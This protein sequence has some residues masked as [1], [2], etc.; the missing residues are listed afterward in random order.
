MTH[1]AASAPDPATF[2]RSRRSRLIDRLAEARLDAAVLTD[3]REIAYFT[4][5]TLRSP[6]PACLLIRRTGETLLVCGESEHEHNADEIVQYGWHDGGT[7][8]TD[9]TP[10][11]L[12]EAATR[13][14]L[15]TGRIGVQFESIS[16]QVC[17]GLGL[18]TFQPIDAVL[19]DLERTKDALDLLR[20]NDAIQANLAALAAAERAIV[21]GATELEVFAAACR[22]AMLRAGKKVVHDG[23][24]RCGAPGGSCRNR[25]IASGEIYTIDAWTQHNGYWSDL[26]R[27]FAVGSASN[28]QRELVEHVRGAHERVLPLLKPGATG[29]ELWQALDGALREHASVAATGLVHH[30]GHGVGLRLHEA[31]DINPKVNVPLRAGDVICIEPGAYTPFANIRIEET[32]L[33]TANGARCLSKP[34]A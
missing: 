11:M 14:R 12:A 18:S 2:A 19:F 3:P 5:S 28:E 4:A 1:P 8:P 13:F 15:D 23:D 16:A 30:G 27:A 20:I 9:L 33:I 32:Y 7:I 31:P 21:P 6:A 24:Y 22:G 34:H 10:R 17:R 26:A 25:P 29:G